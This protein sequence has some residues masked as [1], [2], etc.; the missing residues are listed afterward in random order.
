M[1]AST[2]GEVVEGEDKTS[3]SFLDKFVI[4]PPPLAGLPLEEEQQSPFHCFFPNLFGL[5]FLGFFFF[6]ILC[7]PSVALASVIQEKQVDSVPHSHTVHT[8]F[9]VLEQRNWASNGEYMCLYA[10]SAFVCHTFCSV[11]CGSYANFDRCEI[12]VVPFCDDRLL[13]ARKCTIFQPDIKNMGK[14]HT[15]RLYWAHVS[16]YDLLAR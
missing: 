7:F 6:W 5:V 4:Y 16:C 3:V 11:S 2:C 9:L 13:R 12:C 10:V 15:F 14:N 1:Q 8:S